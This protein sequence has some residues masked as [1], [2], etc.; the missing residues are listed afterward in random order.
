M[1][2]ADDSMLMFFPWKSG[3]YLSKARH[4]TD[5]DRYIPFFWQKK[6]CDRATRSP[7]P[8]YE[9]RAWRLTRVYLRFESWTATHFLVCRLPLKGQSKIL[10]QN[11]NNLKFIRTVL[12]QNA[13]WGITIWYFIFVQKTHPSVRWTHGRISYS[14]YGF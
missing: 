3:I 4:G 6:R 5:I 11:W 10:G 9:P 14:I 12:Y 2:Y 8:L 1:P 7:S 13:S